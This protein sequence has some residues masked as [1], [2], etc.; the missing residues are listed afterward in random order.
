MELSRKKC[1]P[2]EGGVP[3]LTPEEVVD[4]MERVDPG[5]H[6][7]GKR[8]AREFTLKDFK[9]AM[10]LINKVAVI[11]ERE[12]HH[13]DIHLERWNHVRFVLYTHAI[14]G[15]HENDFIL[16]AKID[17]AAARKDY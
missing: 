17:A 4:Y 16:A 1:V 13:P 3:P 12:G 14:G 11:A 7:G 15:L 10:G 2:C 5:W 9:A 6:L 8:I